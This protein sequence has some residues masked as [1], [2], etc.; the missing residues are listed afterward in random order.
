MLLAR[1]RRDF[2]QLRSVAKR[3]LIDFGGKSAAH[4]GSL[5]LLLLQTVNVK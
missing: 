2:S 3:L 4:S 1:S 5:E